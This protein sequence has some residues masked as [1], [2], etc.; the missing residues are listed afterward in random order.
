M[1]VKVECESCKAPYTIDERRIPAGGL[2]VRCPKCATTF[3][4]RKPGASMRPAAAAPKPAPAA[5]PAAPAASE[6]PGLD[7]PA[8]P[9]P[10][11]ARPRTRS[12]TIAFAGAPG[13][14]PG[15]ADLD[16]FKLPATPPAQP[17]ESSVPPPV[18]PPAAA[19]PAAPAEPVAPRIAPAPAK[20]P[21]PSAPKHDDLPALAGLPPVPAAGGD[22][23]PAP[24][25]VAR[26][27]VVGLG[28]AL[29]G[30]GAAAGGGHGAK[31][32]PDSDLPAPAVPKATAKGFGELDLPA[33]GGRGAAKAP[34]H[35][36]LPAV[37]AR[38]MGDR[39]LPAFT[40]RTVPEVPAVR[41]PARPAA[42]PPAPT[43]TKGLGAIDL[44]AVATPQ[45]ASKISTG[46]LPAVGAKRIPTP[47]KGGFGDLDLPAA[48]PHEHDLPATK[49]GFGDLDLPAAAPQRHDLPA[50]KGGLGERD[51]PIAAATRKPSGDFGDLDFDEAGANL[52]L[53]REPS[54]AKPLAKGGAAELGVAK[55]MVGPA[56]A[57]ARGIDLDLAAPPA[58]L[59]GAAPAPDLG[60]RS[61]TAKG[62]GELDF[63][64]APR[65][66]PRASSGLDA[67]P[68]TSGSHGMADFGELEL[69]GPGDEAGS[70]DAL[71]LGASPS[72][73]TFGGELEAPRGAQKSPSLRIQ[74]NEAPGFGE[75]ETPSIPAPPSVPGGLGASAQA[76]G[77]AFGEV[78]LGG[79]AGGEDDMEFGAIPQERAG[80]EDHAGALEHAPEPAPLKAREPGA[81]PAEQAPKKKGKTGRV[82]LALVG[83]LA[84]A[85]GA[86]EFSP[87]GA[88]GRNVIADRFNAP[89]YAAL[90]RE[91]QARTEQALA[92]DTLAR[93]S[94][95]MAAIDR[96]ADANP[97]YA[98]VI[99]YAAYVGWAHELR[100]GKDGGVDL[101][102][103]ALL[104]RAIEKA[105][106]SRQLAEAARDVLGGNLAPARS[107]LQGL[108]S[109]DAKNVDAA[110]TLGELELR[111]K[112]PKEAIAAFT[113]AKAAQDSPR[114]RAG[115]MRAYAAAGDLES[116]R[117]QAEEIV[118]KSPTHVTSRLF[119]AHYAW[120]KLRD[121]HKALA[122]VEELRKPALVAAASPPEQVD[123]L[124]LEGTV[125]FDRGRVSDAKAAFEQ[126]LQAAKGTPAALPQ[127]GLGEVYLANGQYPAAIAAFKAAAEAAP[128]LTL[129]K[130]GIA[131]AQLKLE[132]P[133]DAQATLAPLKDPALASEI[134]Y[135]QGQAAEKL[136]P[137]KPQEAIKIYTAA[138]QAQPSEVK[139]YIALA[140]LQAKTGEADLAGKTLD[141]ALKAVPPSDKL[142]LAVGELKFRQGRY[143]EALAEFDKALE[144]TPDNLDALFD[145]G[146]T[147][148]RMEGAESMSAGKATL[149]ALEKK[150]PK[151]P[152][153][154]LEMGY[155]YQQTHQLAEALKRY[156]S[157]LEAAP[158]D[159]DVKL[160]VGRAMVESRDPN[161]E[162]TLRDVLDKCA[163]GSSA[164]DVCQVEAKH[165]LGRAL[166]NRNAPADAI[167]FLK[168]AVDK[169]DNNAAYH[170]YYGWALKELDRLDEA[171]AQVSRAL[172]L[173]K[174]VGDAY[175]LRAEILVKQQKFKDAIA[176]AE[177]ALAL[178]PSRYEA[179][180]TI[181]MALKEG[182]SGNGEAEEQ[183]IAEWDKAI[184]ADPNNPKAPFWRYQ[185]ADTLYYRN[186]ISR[187]APYIKEA[188]KQLLERDQKPAWL[189][190]AYFYLGMSI[191]FV[192]KAEAKKALKTYLDT[193]IGSSDP[194]RDDAKAAYAEAGGVNTGP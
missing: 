51:L 68:V 26:R 149:D 117:K 73:P 122:L 194:A 183:A 135:W 25:A 38:P 175:W 71:H 34:S 80:G 78:D 75:I 97:R 24:R 30:L 65:P 86:L 158:N 84:L 169:D 188:I 5:A 103:T 110:V 168:Q 139:P 52:P 35:P 151:H 94:D 42:A 190:K 49:G 141:A 37:A 193:S 22:K 150:D 19:K 61:G 50:T 10:G 3:V 109:Q 108:L 69:P 154:A 146:R 114:T 120:D 18:R 90:M 91:A 106:P 16:S 62:F 180:A 47:L 76:G 152:G 163:T 132:K 74:A 85:G 12:A 131:R 118:K 41:P 125:L 107:A 98:P 111:A 81:A 133:A 93:S 4:I 178:T 115:L 46:D 56:V 192:D 83:V 32:T 11:P 165:Y 54:I 176:L 179:H 8:V 153:L 23:G 147:Q 160:Q 7:L 92:D 159:D 17:S 100:F 177:K 184:R 140:N 64:V 167:V 137:D 155:Y 58:E 66:G 82:V 102:A 186:Q 45:A 72:A 164:V 116:A 174:S 189:P 130:I 95:A 99:A 185:V 40:K 181:A 182:A 31:A 119:L 39:D 129:A 143:A 89:R 1:A 43:A 2:R 67:R 44:P 128:D 112:Q 13:A 173:D 104:G 113:K 172:E 156:Q 21:P 123:T 53:A 57:P 28:G 6:P 144:L 60:L 20:P 70:S 162:A 191:R 96:D 145:K 87:Y 27:T 161:A 14:L 148:L 77:M 88:F 79:G 59:F 142:H 134:G 166:L 171:D 124:S 33:I 36:D 121:E 170:L 187:A 105:G 157:A 63:D 9:A 48:A 15:S 127:L 101:K 29:P 136:A 55:T 126:A 138:I